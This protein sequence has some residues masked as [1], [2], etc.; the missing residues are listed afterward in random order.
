MTNWR[1]RRWTDKRWATTMMNWRQ[2]RW[3]D[4]TMM[5]GRQHWT[6]DENDDDRD[7]TMD[8]NNDEWT[9]TMIDIL[10]DVWTTTMVIGRCHIYRNKRTTQAMYLW[11]VYITHNISN[12]CVPSGPTP[13]RIRIGGRASKLE[14]YAHLD[15]GDWAIQTQEILT[16]CFWSRYKMASSFVSNIPKTPLCGNNSV[17]YAHPTA[18]VHRF[19]DI[20]HLHPSDND[21]SELASEAECLTSSKLINI[22]VRAIQGQQWET[23]SEAQ[24]R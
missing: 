2:R 9:T 5:D 22:M 10:D 1:Q 7:W 24:A 21:A 15:H 20:T 13:G 6:I 8:D 16:S 23:R 3:M 12:K 17:S 19:T 4:T 11:Y 18:S 14:K